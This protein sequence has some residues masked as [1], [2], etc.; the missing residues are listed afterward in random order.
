MKYLR[1]LLALLVT[2]ILLPAAEKPNVVFILIDD[3]SHYGIGA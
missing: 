3:L 2:T 1:P